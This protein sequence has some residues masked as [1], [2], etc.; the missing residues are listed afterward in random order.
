MVLYHEA[1]L[2][3]WVLLHELAQ[4]GVLL[5]LTPLIYSLRPSSQHWCLSLVLDLSQCSW[6]MRRPVPIALMASS[7]G[8]APLLPPTQKSAHRPMLLT[9]CTGL[10]WPPLQGYV[11]HSGATW[12]YAR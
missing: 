7:T 4:H 2:V 5:L 11:L 8:F 1:I 10:T 6:Q 9:A 12:N 3:M